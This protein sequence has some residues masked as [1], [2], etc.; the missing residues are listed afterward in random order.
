M[1]LLRFNRE[2]IGRHALCVRLFY[3]ITSQK[4]FGIFAARKFLKLNRQIIL[5]FLD[6]IDFEILIANSDFK[7]VKSYIPL[8]F[9]RLFSTAETIL[10]GC[11]RQNLAR[12]HARAQSR[13]GK[14]R[15][16]RC[17]SGAPQKRAN[18]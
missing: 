16:I 18:A 2:N 10:S 1:Y 17:K 3:S 8:N 13:D 4:F 9:N 11:A 12:P 5:S 6:L 14:A 15:K 7:Q